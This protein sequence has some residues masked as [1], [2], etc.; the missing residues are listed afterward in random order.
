MSRRKL[1]IA[2]LV[3]SVALATSG[4]SPSQVEPLS[5]DAGEGSAE[6][7]LSVSPDG[8]VFLSYLI[9]V[10]DETALR[11]H[12]MTENGWSEAKTIVQGPDLLVNWADF[13]SVLPLSDRVLAAHWLTRS[14]GAAYAY[15][16]K[17]A[18]SKDAGASWSEP[19]NIHS[20]T[21]L[22]EHGFVSLFPNAEGFAAIWLDGRRFAEESVEGA[23]TQLFARAISM[24]GELGPE[25]VVDNKVCDCCQTDIA[26]TDRGAIAAYRNRT[27]Q[28]IRDIYVARY[29]E[30]SWSREV[31]VAR[32]NWEITG[33][34]V[35]GPAVA[36]SGNNVVVAWFTASPKKRVR[37]ATS[38]DGG[39]SFSA[40]V[41]VASRYPI[42]RVDTIVG[43]DGSALVSWVEGNEGALMV[44]GISGS[45]EL[46]PIV[47]VTRM[48]T[49]RDAGFPKMVRFRDRVIVAWT[50]TSDDLSSVRT[51]SVS[52]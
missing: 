27:D 47:K 17:V 8:D 15:D 3:A 41:D 45:G 16:A 46:G 31:N 35:N 52:L 19:K 5:L 20:D 6:P 4:C 23:S 48:A 24:D 18:T 7:Y 26:V 29:E 21:S 12:T 9:P 37:S 25:T 14:E 42:G 28:E 22:V 36:A 51:A 39:K 43:D 1:I 38:N 32:D 44:R 50:D 10:G 33:C 40:P 30:G 49:H 34:P 2:G 11:F 13:P